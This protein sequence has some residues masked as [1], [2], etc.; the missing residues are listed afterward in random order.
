MRRF[1]SL[2]QDERERV[3]L[4]WADSRVVQR[5]AA[6]QAL[7]K[8]TL[9]AYYG[10]GGD[11]GAR[12][13]AWDAIGYPGPL[14]P[15]QNP[16]PR[17][18][19]PLQVDEDTTL[20]CDVV[21][22]GSGAG[23]G[24]A[25]AVLA[26]AGLDVVIVEAGRYF[27]EKDFDGAELSGFDRLYLNGGGMASADA[28]V[29]LLAAQGLGGTTLVNYTFSFRTPDNVRARVGRRARPARGGL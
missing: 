23:G 26:Q 22:V 15:P 12:N 19:E 3:L 5:R 16:P 21:V 6:F 25:A 18:I 27:S 14:G 24:T 2:A 7:R 28:S 13:P 4:S 17:T 8:G 20:E 1:T 10:Q 9:L 29:G 11:N